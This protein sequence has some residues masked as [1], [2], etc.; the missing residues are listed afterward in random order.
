MIGQM[1]MIAMIKLIVRLGFVLCGS[2]EFNRVR[3]L[4]LE[5]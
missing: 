2:L 3:E 1:A 4:R 5:V